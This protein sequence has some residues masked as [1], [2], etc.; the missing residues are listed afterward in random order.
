[1][2]E[3]FTVDTSP[4]TETLGDSLT[5]DEQES[6]TIGEEMESQQ[7]SLLAGKYKDAAELEKAYIEL[8]SKLGESGKETTEEVTKETT[9]EVEPESKDTN[10]TEFLDRLWDEATND[11]YT[12]DTLKELSEMNPRDLAQM[13]LEYRSKNQQEQPQELTPENITKLKSV[14]GGDD[15][16]D[17]MMGWAKGSLADQEIAMFDKVMESGDTLACYF[18]IQAL[19]YRFDDASGVEGKMITGKAPS[20]RGDQFKSNAQLVSAMN[21]PKY[22]NDPA[23]RQEVMEKL[24]RSNLQF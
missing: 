19:K 3:T 23:Y 17:K 9:E 7:E 20:S 16:Y 24:E 11:K 15:G 4:Q 8:Q 12:D 1:M 21:D 13:H 10:N 5:P 2:A 14:V 6:L 22:D 18:A